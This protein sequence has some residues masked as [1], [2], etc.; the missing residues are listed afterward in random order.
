MR[1][2]F[3]GNFRQKKIE[4][5]LSENENGGLFSEQDFRKGDRFGL[6]GSGYNLPEFAS[7]YL[8][9]PVENSQR[10]DTRGF[11]QIPITAPAHYS[12]SNGISS[13]LEPVLFGK[14]FIESAPIFVNAKQFQAILRRRAKKFKKIQRKSNDQSVKMKKKFKYDSRSRHAKNRAREKDGKFRKLSKFADNMTEATGTKEED[15]FNREET[16]PPCNEEEDQALVHTNAVSNGMNE[17]RYGLKIEPRLE[18]M[19]IELEDCFK[20][21]RSDDEADDESID[22]TELTGGKPSMNRQD[23][24]FKGR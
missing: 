9:R 5:N 1:E 22:S 8:Y 20:R 2:G 12:Q 19:E 10:T 4:D 21:S 3:S 16:L 7:Q 15:N 18:K 23:S 24:L 6:V 11:I 17:Q 13:T 14:H